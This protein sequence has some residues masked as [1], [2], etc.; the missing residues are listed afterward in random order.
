[1]EHEAALRAREGGELGAR[2]VLPVGDE[3]RARSLTTLYV[4]PVRPPTAAAA[5]QRTRAAMIQPSQISYSSM[6]SQIPKTMVPII[7]TAMSA[8]PTRETRNRRTTS[9]GSAARHRPATSTE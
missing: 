2:L 4:A 7:P 1:M 5:T 8:S 3:E 6:A 9:L